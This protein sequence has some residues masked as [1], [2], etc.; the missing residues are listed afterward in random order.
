MTIAL[1]SVTGLGTE[2]VGVI[3]KKDANGE[4]DATTVEFIHWTGV[5]SLS[6]TLTDTGD[7][8]ISGSYGSASQAHDANDYFEVWVS[9]QYYSSQ[10]AGF[11]AEH[12]AAGVHDSTKVAV[13]SGGYSTTLTTTASTNVTLPT[14][15][16]L[17][18]L[19]GTQTLTNKTI[20]RRVLSATS[21][22]TDT[23]SSLNCDNYDM[24]IVTAQA[25]AL[26]FNNPSGTPT[27]GQTL[28]LA[29]TGTAARDLT[30]DTQYESSNL[31]TLP[32]T[33]VTTL[34]TDIGVQWRADTSKWRCV[35]VA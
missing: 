35:A 33:T 17:A 24:F 19:T 4:V 15:G 21:Y 6:L 12:S 29:V 8:G 7:R 1:N 34:R 20:R 30:Y 22:T 18:S 32:T 26:K 31:A 16:T 9:S 23:G 3:F 27:D 10:R 5:S 2:G 11:V 13:V 28:W 14:T 25:G